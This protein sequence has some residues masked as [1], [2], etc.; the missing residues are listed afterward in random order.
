MGTCVPDDSQQSKESV[1]QSESEEEVLQLIT[2]RPLS[3]DE[4]ENVQQLITFGTPAEYGISEDEVPQEEE[5]ASLTVT[6]DIPPPVP[7]TTTETLIQL[8]LPTT[9]QTSGG[10]PKESQQCTS[11]K[12]LFGDAAA[13]ALSF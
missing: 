1:P 7:N 13:I 3:E 9:S 2:I 10:Q 11:S 8:S 5:N 12:V 6:F 4:E